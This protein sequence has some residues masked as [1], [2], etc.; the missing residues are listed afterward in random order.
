MHGRQGPMKEEWPAGQLEIHE[1]RVF[2]QVLP[3]GLDHI[4]IAIER[5]LFYTL[6]GFPA[7]A[8]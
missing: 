4:L 8:W 5:T 3:K 6:Y 7:V 2:N 1:P